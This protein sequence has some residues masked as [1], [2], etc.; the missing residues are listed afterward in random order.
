MASR[1]FTSRGA[2]LH[3]AEN[4]G[5]LS[6]LLSLDALHFVEQVH[7]TAVHFIA[8]V[9]QANVQ[10]DAIVTQLP[11]VGVAIL[12]ADCLP[13][14][15]SAPDTVGA[16]HAGRRGLLAGV[17]EQTLDLM[18]AKSG[19]PLSA[20]SATIGPSICGQCYEVS[21]EM[22]TELVMQFPTLAHGVGERHLNLQAEAIRRLRQGGVAQVHDCE[23]HFSYRSGDLQERQAGVISL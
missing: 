10:A 19:Y 11:R 5:F 13:I 21:Q 6:E 20:F 15:V 16:V 2:S 18:A 17:I 1:L 23:N 12:S 14:L 8:E 22:R 3:L 9:D 7:G 4:Q